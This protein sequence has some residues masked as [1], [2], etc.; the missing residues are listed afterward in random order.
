MSPRAIALSVIIVIAL[1]ITSGAL[2]ALGYI[3]IAP[4]PNQIVSVSEVN[5]EPGGSI[6]HQ[7]AIQTY[8]DVVLTV[9]TQQNI[10]FIQTNFGGANGTTAT[11]TVNGQTVKATSQIYVT[12]TPKQPYATLSLLEQPI[13]WALGANG[14]DNASVSAGITNT[15]KSNPVNAPAQTAKFYV[16]NPNDKVWHL[17]YPVD[18][19]VTKAGGSN[20]FTTTQSVDAAQQTSV[21]I[22]NPY[23]SNQNLTIDNLGLLMGSVTLPSINDPV[24]YQ[25]TQ[26]G[27]TQW[28]GFDNSQVAIQSLYS[29]YWYGNTYSF[30]SQGGEALGNAPDQNYW[31]GGNACGPELRGPT[32]AFNGQSTSP[33]SL[34]YACDTY[35]PSGTTRSPGW[36]QIVAYNEGSNR[37]AQSW[38]GSEVYWYSPMA[39]SLISPQIAS[40]S[41]AVMQSG[42]GN[43]YAVDSETCSGLDLTDWLNAQGYNQF[44]S[45]YGMQNNWNIPTSGSNAYSELVLNLPN[46]KFE[47]VGTA[48]MQI[49]ISTT[50]VDTLVYQ[51]NDAQ[52]KITRF[53]AV[54]T[55]LD[56]SEP[57]TVSV[58]V[59]NDGTI[60]GTPT[61]G[62]YQGSDLLDITYP[63]FPALAPGQSY[64]VQVT[65]TGLYVSKQTNDTVTLFVEND[66]S[67]VTDSKT[68]A[69]SISPQP[70]L[71]SETFLITNINSPKSMNANSQG[72]M[73]VSL[74]SIGAAGTAYLDAVSSAP[75]FLVV[76]PENTS[77]TMGSGNTVALPFV[78]VAPPNE[79]GTL[80]TISISV[81]N[82]TSSTVDKVSINIIGS[83]GSG[84]NCSSYC[85]P[86]PPPAWPLSLVDTI[87]LILIIGAV[88]GTVVYYLKTRRH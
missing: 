15:Y 67:Q 4:K 77:Q 37:G 64:T 83:S 73:V 34:T 70:G 48:L 56:S 84:G 18:I 86:P 38:P 60:S 55:N 33:W 43:S 62:L 20:E 61:I 49:L 27:L 26:Y 88:V 80:V 11:G 46:N 53:N 24:F 76:A 30:N 45:Q 28:Y 81:S 39:P 68:L 41:P 5:L 23:D 57:T 6:Q 10:P 40:L 44:L 54:N 74:K 25:A 32:C 79:N 87:L 78:L 65:A 42:Y 85:P 17:H 22:V 52:F 16:V 29:Q 36:Q 1:I 59:Q 12:L 21:T 50:L 9:N 72:T 82:G 51:V 13:R 35:G 14:Y 7:Y 71:G 47:N 63:T 19:T 8:W 58:T 3:P 66:A 69:F 2:Y 31:K 75:S